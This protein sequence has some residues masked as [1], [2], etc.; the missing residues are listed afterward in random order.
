MTSPQPTM[1]TG[2]NTAL[3]AAVVVLAASVVAGTTP[4]SAAGARLAAGLLTHV[5]KEESPRG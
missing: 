5:V 4:P 3:G 2:V 1:P